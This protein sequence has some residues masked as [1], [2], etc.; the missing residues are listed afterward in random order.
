MWFGNDGN[1]FGNDLA[2]ILAMM[3]MI[4]LSYNTIIDIFEQKEDEY[5]DLRE[6]RKKNKNAKKI[7]WI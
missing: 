3:A 1:D 4:F 6:N 5:D 2:M 7:F